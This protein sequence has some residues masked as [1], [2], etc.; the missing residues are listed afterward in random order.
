M[1]KFTKL[2][3][4]AVLLIPL[5]FSSCA[6]IFSGTKQKITLTGNVEAPVDLLVDGVAYSNVKFPA[7]VKIKRKPD[8]SQIMA[9]TPGYNAER[10]ELEKTFNPV[11]WISVASFSN[12]IAMYV[13]WRKGAHKKAVK[14]EITLDFS[15]A[16]STQEMYDTYIDFGTEHYK[17][18]LLDPALFY[19]QEAYQLDTLNAIALQKIDSTYARMDYLEELAWRK[20]ERAEMWSMILQIFGLALQTTADVMA[21]TQSTNAS[22]GSVSSSGSS[23]SGG[24]TCANLQ[25][26]YTQTKQ[27]LNGV[28]KSYA[29]SKTKEEKGIDNSTGNATVKGSS[30]QAMRTYEQELARLQREAGKYG[31]VLH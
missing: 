1:V 12:P 4:A 22:G 10:Q 29:Y 25:T 17:A 5:V 14:K 20:A 23:R 30:G 21:I 15:P 27:K 28:T 7:K 18:D 16:T 8:T 11:A 2:F 3:V 24:N 9:F 26:L 13:D 31:C 6:T 19:F